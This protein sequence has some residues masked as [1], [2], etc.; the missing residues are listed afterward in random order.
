MVGDILK[1]K[2][3]AIDGECEAASRPAVDELYDAARYDGSR[4][5]VPSFQAAGAVW[6]RVI[7]EKERSFIAEVGRVLRTPGATL[8]EHGR[9]QIQ[10]VIDTS[11]SE[12]RYLER[13]KQ[14]PE[15]VAR[16]AASYGIA[17]DLNTY[18]FD[19]AD[20]AYRVG[21][22]NSLRKARTN[23]LAELALQTQSNPPDSVLALSKWWRYIRARPWT[24]LGAMLLLGIVPWLISK[25][26]PA[27]VL[28]WLGLP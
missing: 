28:G 5:V 2:L 9:K 26:S 10:E 17:L 19:L 23:V 1:T 4:F 21:V 18:R 11:F 16:R 6:L 7:A 12:S 24:A 3:E 22:M 20:S 27:D 25:A 8:N 13:L 14:F 15:G